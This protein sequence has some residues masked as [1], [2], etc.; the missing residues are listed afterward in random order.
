MWKHNQRNLEKSW[1]SRT[2]KKEKKKKKKKMLFHNKMEA[3]KVQPKVE[4]N[5]R[6][7]RVQLQLASER[8]QSEPPHVELVTVFM[9]D[10][11]VGV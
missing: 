2:A 4:R 1:F 11:D 9:V 6:Q 8:V 10:P 3:E 5:I 7:V